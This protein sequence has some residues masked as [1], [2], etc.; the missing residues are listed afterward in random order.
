MDNNAFVELK[1]V[2]ARSFGY[3]D[4]DPQAIALEDVS[5]ALDAIMEVAGSGVLFSY[6]VDETNPESVV[7]RTSVHIDIAVNEDGHVDVTNHNLGTVKKI[8]ELK[9]ADLVEL[10]KSIADLAKPAGKAAQTT[11]GKHRKPEQGGKHAAPQP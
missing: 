11:G 7:I 5:Y 8:S 10:V 6:E 1:E 3:M 2:A 9:Q 4:R